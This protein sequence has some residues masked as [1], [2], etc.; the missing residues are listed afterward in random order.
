MYSWV[1]EAAVDRRQGKSG[2][3]Y[4]NFVANDELIVTPGN[5]TD[6]RYIEQTIYE[7]ASLYDIR[8][9]AFDRWNSS[10]LIAALAEEGLPVEP[11]GQGFASMSPAIKQLEIWIRSQQIAHNGNRLLRW[12]VS[13]V[14]AKSDP[15]GNLKFDKAKSSDKID[16]AQAGQMSSAVISLKASVYVPQLWQ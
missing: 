7:A 2:A 15:A 4:N 5:V 11:Y 1:S 16:V 6:Y 12:C 8:A 9:I 3:D 13:N 10:S 14:Q